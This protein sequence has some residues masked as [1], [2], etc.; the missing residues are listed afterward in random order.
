MTRVPLLVLEAQ[1][2]RDRTTVAMT[3]GWSPKPSPYLYVCSSLVSIHEFMGGA[4]CLADAPP[5][6]SRRLDLMHKNDL[7]FLEM[8]LGPS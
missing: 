8:A 6:A 5:M 3:A 7:D 2:I 4:I 1:A